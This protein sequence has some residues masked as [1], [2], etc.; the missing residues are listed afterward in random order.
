[1][2]NTVWVAYAKAKIKIWPDPNDL[3]QFKVVEIPD[4][5]KILNLIIVTGSEVWASSLNKVFAL[6][7]EAKVLNSFDFNASVTCLSEVDDTVWISTQDGSIYI[8]ELKKRFKRVIDSK[9]TNIG[10]LL[11]YKP[12]ISTQ[13]E[14]NYA[15]FSFAK[16]GKE[17]KK[18]KNSNPFLESTVKTVWVGGANSITRYNARNGQ[19]VSNEPC[20]KGMVLGLIAVEDK[21]W[22]TSYDKNIGV[23]DGN[24]GKLLKMLQGHTGAVLA[25]EYIGD[26]IWTTSWDKTILVWHKNTYECNTILSGYHTDMVT[27]IKVIYKKNGCQVWTGSGSTD[28]SV[29]IFKVLSKVGKKRLSFATVY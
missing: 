20:H 9:T 16:L 17:V 5:D 28:G 15:S 14:S 23:F 6:D 4:C 27:S 3:T 7:F 11:V 22:S 29:C 1:V 18:A 25:I 12:F 2:E 24:S 13:S 19:F 8:V 21:V 10:C 26:Y